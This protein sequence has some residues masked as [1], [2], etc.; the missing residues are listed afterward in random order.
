MTYDETRAALDRI[1]RDLMHL[2]NANNGNA[3]ELDYILRA[4][5]VLQEER[6]S[7]NA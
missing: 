4:A 5:V 1:A 6:E 3:R 7:R 2:Q